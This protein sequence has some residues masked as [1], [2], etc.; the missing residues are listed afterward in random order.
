VYYANTDDGH[1]VIG[2][3]RG[4]VPERD[5][6]NS[7]VVFADADEITPEPAVKTLQSFV[8]RINAKQMQT[9]VAASI[10]ENGDLKLSTTDAKV[11]SAISIGPGKITDGLIG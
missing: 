2:A 10:D 8:D 7:F 9:H 1:L 3:L 6:K 11:V 5:I 4:D